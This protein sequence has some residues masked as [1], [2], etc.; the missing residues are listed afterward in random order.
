M[1]PAGALSAL[2]LPSAALQPVR[3]GKECW[4]LC[5]GALV[6]AVAGRDPRGPAHRQRGAG[7]S[8]SSTHGGSGCRS[9][10]PSMRCGVLRGAALAASTGAT[11]VAAPGGM[12]HGPWGG[13]PCL[14]VTTAGR[15]DGVPYLQRACTQRGA[16]AGMAPLYVQDACMLCLGATL[17]CLLPWRAWTSI[18]DGMM[19]RV[20][21]GS[22]TFG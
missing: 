20:Q 3:M 17:L 15:Y 19:R 13:Q 5:A 11:C 12:V 22:P 9:V 7:T 10:R 18:L 1:D 6:W 14:R 21:A 16:G 8:Q 4:R 2:L